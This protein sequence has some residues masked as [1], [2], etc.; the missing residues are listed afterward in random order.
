MTFYQIQLTILTHAHLTEK[1]RENNMLKQI[2]DLN[3][4]K[5][6]LILWRATYLTLS[7]KFY[8]IEALKGHTKALE[9]FETAYVFIY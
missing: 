7:I 5:I 6:V 9:T 3:A 2:T 8:I 4:M 1:N